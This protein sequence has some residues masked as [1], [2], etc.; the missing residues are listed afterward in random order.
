MLS[1]DLITVICFFVLSLWSLFKFRFVSKE[2]KRLAESAEFEQKMIALNLVSSF[3][4][5]LLEILAQEAQAYFE[6]SIRAV[7][8]DIREI[9]Q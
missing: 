2:L 6:A 3:S 4:K 1:L 8:N 7:E 5:T 9:E